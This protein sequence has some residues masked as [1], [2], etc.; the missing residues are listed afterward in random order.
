MV[1]RVHR[2]IKDLFASYRDRAKWLLGRWRAGGHRRRDLVVSTLVAPI[3]IPLLWVALIVARLRRRQRPV[4]VIGEVIGLSFLVDLCERSIRT[5]KDRLLLLVVLGRITNKAVFAA[6]SDVQLSV[7]GL[8]AEA[9][10]ISLLSVPRCLGQISIFEHIGL[11]EARTFQINAGDVY[12]SGSPALEPTAHELFMVPQVIKKVRDEHLKGFTCVSFKS[13][14]Y[15]DSTTESRKVG[16]YTARLSQPSTFISALR[17]IYERRLL[18]VRVGVMEDDLPPDVGRLMFDYARLARTEG[19]DAWCAAN[20]CFTV[21]DATGF[22]WLATAANR[23]V[24]ATNT[25]DPRLRP[26]RVVDRFT[27]LQFWSVAERRLLNLA[28]ALSLTWKTS[29][30]DQLERLG[31]EV[32]RN[33]EEILAGSVEE[34]CDL[35]EGRPSHFDTERVADLRHRFNALYEARG[36]PWRDKGEISAAFILANEDLLPR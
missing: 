31:L 3:L 14:Q 2:T 12:Q 32:I 15:E 17:V 11:P 9:L 16:R 23:P 26:L 20:G 24:V 30:R 27:T 10:H 5:W 28:E 1:V 13:R 33:S 18:P 35:T 21:A 7:H 29:R 19:G 22:W 8:V 34:M 36:I 25:Y 6:Y 4:I